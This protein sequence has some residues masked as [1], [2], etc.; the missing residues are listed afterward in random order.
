[1]ILRSQSLVARSRDLTPRVTKVV[2]LLPLLMLGRA[3]AV[4]Q[5]RMTMTMTMTSWLMV[6][7]RTL[8]CTNEIIYG[9]LNLIK[10]FMSL[11]FNNGVISQNDT[12]VRVKHSPLM[13]E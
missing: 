7:R 11:G 6:P 9:S 8:L 13:R 12:Y 10:T 1:M 5:V 3:V 4:T 2:M